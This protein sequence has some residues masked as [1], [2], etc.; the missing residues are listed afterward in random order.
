MADRLLERLHQ[1]GSRRSPPEN[2]RPALEKL[3]A[4]RRDLYVQLHDALVTRI[5]QLAELNGAER[6]LLNQ[7]TQLRALLN[8]RLLWLPSSGIDRH[9]LARP[10]ARQ[11]RLDRSTSRR[12]RQPARRCSSEP[13]T[14][15]LPTALVLLA[16]GALVLFSRRLLK[17]LARIS[18][19]VGRYST[20]NYL[21]TPEALLISALL[22]IKT[23]LLFGYAGWLLVQPPPAPISPPASA[24]DCSQ[25]RRFSLFLRLIQFI[26]VENGLFSAHF[27]W[28]ERARAVALPEHR[29][30]E[31]RHHADRLHPRH[32]QRQQRAEPARWPWAASPSLPAALPCRSS[33]PASS[34]RAAA[35]S[36]TGL[37]PTHPAVDYAR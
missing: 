16:F 36:P 17:R 14:R 15:P 30:A 33:S 23:P 5:A 29:L 26:C 6:D 9:R 37:T 24:P 12:G 19:A 31:V 27:G 1:A 3:V 20:D 22:A 11:F 2:V 4:A 25:S 28:S 8:S 32:D 18:D 13:S 35:S 34:T 7:T 21:R 10:G